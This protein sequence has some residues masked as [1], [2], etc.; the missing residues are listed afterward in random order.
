MKTFLSLAESCLLTPKT[1]ITF[2]DT[3][4]EYLSLSLQTKQKNV[5]INY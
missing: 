3:Y 2:K 5:K 1:K 4:H